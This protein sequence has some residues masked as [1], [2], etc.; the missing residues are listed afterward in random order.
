[1][2][3]LLLLHLAIA[4]N[5]L[6]WRHKTLQ[7]TDL[8]KFALAADLLVL[9]NADYR[10]VCSASNHTPPGLGHRPPEYHK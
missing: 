10:V 3:K 2:S 7:S 9:G 5:A 8:E 4:S 1:M 6:Q